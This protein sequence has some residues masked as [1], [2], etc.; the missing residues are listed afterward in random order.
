MAKI[1]YIEDELSKNIASIKKFFNPILG[2]KRF[3]EKMDALE[4][5][6]RVY[7]EDITNICNQSS[8]LDICY[9][10]PMALER[11]INNHSI[12]DLIIIDRNLSGYEYSSELDDIIQM[13]QETGLDYTDDRLLSLYEREGDLLLLILLRFNPS[14]KDRIYYLTANTKDDLKSSHDLQS[15]M[16][17]NSFAKEHI[18]EKGSSRES[19]ITDII[20]NVGKF[21]IQ[22]Q[23]KEQCTAFRNQGSE[24][25]VEQFLDVIKYYESGDWKVFAGCLRNLL[26]KMLSEIA[27]AINDPNAFFWDEYSYLKISDFLN[28]AEYGLLKYNNKFQLEY[29]KIIR[30]FCTSIHHICSAYG[31]HDDNEPSDNMSKRGK[32]YKSKFSSHSVDA[33]LNQICEVIIWYDKALD[34]IKSKESPEES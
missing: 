27:K 14:Y 32:M 28:S 11:I 16:D 3:K 21:K 5:Q 18:I 7:P 26:H 2:I 1:L 12:Y 4:D 33:L 13:I 19:I 30:N 20:L 24:Y 10:F 34:I 22:N 6:A 17:V 31:A 9:T 23:Y 25:L 8:I 15:L 29:N